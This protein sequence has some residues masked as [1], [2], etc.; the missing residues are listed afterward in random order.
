MISV[1]IKDLFSGG[2]SLILPFGSR[3]GDLVG[4]EDDDGSSAPLE[5]HE[6]FT[7]FGKEYTQIIVRIIIIIACY[8]TIL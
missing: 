3:V 5:V 4:P 8:A 2:G 7:F 6:P 1:S